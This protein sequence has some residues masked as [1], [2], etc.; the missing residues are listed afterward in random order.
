MVV[1]ACFFSCPIKLQDSY[2][3]N[4]S[5][6][7]IL[8]LLHGVSHQWSVVSETTTIGLVWPVAPLI[9]L[10]CNTFDHQYVGKE[11]INMLDFWHGDPEKVASKTTS[12]DWMWQVV[13]LVQP[14]CKILCSS[15]FLERINGYFSFFGWSYSSI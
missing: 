1:C 4:K 6:I 2:L 8:G 9:Q 7:D 15:I 5:N 12:F 3:Q 13:P 14:N 11:S 10:D